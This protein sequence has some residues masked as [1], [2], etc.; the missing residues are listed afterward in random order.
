MMSLTIKNKCSINF[1]FGRGG[2]FT[3]SP[4]WHLFSSLPFHAI[5][6]WTQGQ[7]ATKMSQIS[8]KLLQ[9]SPGRALRSL[10]IAVVDA[11]L[12]DVGD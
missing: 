3:K 12:I 7:N 4:L 5:V 6:I 10:S 9:F 1:H 8:H 11:W 2:D